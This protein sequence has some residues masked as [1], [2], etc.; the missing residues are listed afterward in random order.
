MSAGTPQPA[1]HRTAVFNDGRGHE[2]PYVLRLAERP[3]EARTLIV[4]HGRGANAVPAKFCSADWN[5]LCPLDRYGDG[6]N[7]SWWLGE[8]GDF[9]VAEMLHALIRRVRAD[10][11]KDRGLYFWGSSMGGYGA[12]LHGTLLRARAVYAHI[13]QIRL[14][15]TAYTDGKNKH[16]YD[17]VLGNTERHPYIDLAKLVSKRPSTETPMYFLNQ[18]RFDYRLYLE[19]HCLHFVSAC[20]AAGHAYHLNIDPYPGHQLYRKIPETVQ[21]FDRFDLEIRRWRSHGSVTAQAVPTS[22][23]AS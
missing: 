21:L 16:C 1:A 5:V 6:A 9:F 10:I 3:Q 14:R 23:S 12:I 18:N 17:A 20:N 8:S 13:P 15:G 22:S 7:G 19:Q 2:L 11:G 4:L